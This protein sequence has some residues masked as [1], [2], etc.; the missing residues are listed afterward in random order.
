MLFE[1]LAIGG[2]GLVSALGLGVASR[3]FAVEVD[4][5]VEAVEEALP[6][7][8][9][10]GCGFA[11]CSSAALAIASGK[12]PANICV[13]GGPEVGEAVG[14]IMGVSVGFR[15]PDIA[16]VDC[17]YGTDKAELKY[18][19]DG[20]QDCRAAALLAG[21]PKV[22]EVGCLGLGSCAKACPFGAITIGPDHLPKVDSRICTGCGTCERVCPKNIIHLNSVS[23]RM[24]GF[25]AKYNCLAPCQAT[26]PAQIDIPGYI[27]AIGEG[28]Y[29]DAVT[30][31][32]EHNP[33]P[34]VCG[35]VC[36][37]PCE[38]QCRRGLDDDPININHLKR[39]AA[40]Y[41]MFSGK[42]F[43][44]YCLP[45]NDRKVAIVGGGPAGL[46]C[47]YYLARMGYAPTI[48]EAQP[49]LGG[50][51]RYGIPEYRLPKKIL[52]WEIQGILDLGVEV[53]SGMALGTDFTLEGLRQEGYE[54]IFMGVG[55]WAS[56]SMRVE[57]EDLNGVLPGTDMLIDRGNLKDTPVG[58]RVVIIGGG[59]TA[60]DCA[61]TCWRLGA[62]E[63]TVLYR[64][65]RAEMP[66][67]DI[68]VEEANHEGIKFVYLAAPTKLIGKDGKLTGLE[69]IQMELG[70]PDASGRRRPVPKE[71][72]ETILEC[73]NVISAIGQFP[74]LAFLE[75]DAEAKD[76][77]LTKWNT[78]NANEQVGSTNIPYVFAG[79]DAV[80]GAATAVAAIG[81]GRRAAR[82]IHLYLAGE[83]NT[84]PENWVRDRKEVTTIGNIPAAAPAGAPRVKMPELSVDERANSFIEV[85]LGLTEEM[86]RKE[87][88]RCLQC[89]L[90]CY[91]R[92]EGAEC[93]SCAGK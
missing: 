86:A 75:K 91:R 34:L 40:D 4:P 63:V 45:K 85:E 26:C 57:G 14:V 22:C 13:G 27:K 68:E 93:A 37:H 56:R 88:A 20:V 69:Y 12:A 46:T 2:L 50:M 24:L 31:I 81:A 16:L 66:A 76:L 52:D 21:G 41:E 6:G 70:E 65:S 61:R 32:K 77:E 23:R 19:Y 17:T 29:E 28:R 44:P 71:G 30:I 8:N 47:A 59:N 11:G 10:G 1:A 82:A 36:P 43:H 74:D 87:A 83:D 38:D 80:H 48:F 58:E 84:P 25:N 92:K 73:D 90:I 79:G 78:I 5:L 9:C 7:A 60:M 72:S 53:K 49:Y 39:F 35:R 67:N 64:R 51:L 89:G 54:A 15:E 62:K 18:L 33:L 3:V 55:C 42:R